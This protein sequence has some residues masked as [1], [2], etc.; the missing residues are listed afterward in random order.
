MVAISILMLAIL[1]PLSIASAGLRNSLYARDQ[2]TAYYLAQEGI[3]Y[4]RYARDANYMLRIQGDT[5]R[6]W[7]TDLGNCIVGTGG[8]DGDGCAIDANEWLLDADPAINDSDII[9]ECGNVACSTPAMYVTT[10]GNYTYKTTGGNVPAR[11]TR[12][13]EIDPSVANEIKVTSTVTWQAGGFGTK[14]FTLT[15]YLNDIYRNL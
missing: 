5:T 9:I 15:E 7:L 12:R 13:I 2:I 4:M 3:E 8:T 6:T 14:S 10:G 11:F 1:G